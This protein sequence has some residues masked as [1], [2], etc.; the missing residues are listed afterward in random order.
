M[1][2]RYSDILKNQPIYNFGV[3]GHVAH[4]KSTLVRSIT[5]TKTQK[6]SSEKE[7]NIT[8][9]IGYANSKIYIDESGKF[10]TC[11]SNQDFDDDDSLKIVSHISFVDCPGHEAYMS[12]MI[13]GSAVMN[14][15]VL[16]IASN[17]QIPQPQTYEHFQAVKDLDIDNLLILQNKCDLIESS[18][19]ENILNKIN[20]F[21]GDT[22]LS[23]S[24]II[25]SSIQNDINRQEIVY[26]LVKSS[27]LDNFKKLSDK[28]NE[29]LLMTIIRSFDVNKQNCSYHNLKG[30][31][32]GG[33]LITGFLNVNDIVEIRPGFITNGKFRPIY[34][35]VI[36]LQ[37]DNR[38]LEYAVPGGLIGVGLD[39]DPS[40]SKDNGMLGQTLGKVGSLPDV[41]KEIAVEFSF[42]ERLNKLNDIKFK[43][44]ES[45]LIN[46]NSMNIEAKI[47]KCSKK[48]QYLLLNL[49]KPVCINIDQRVAIFKMISGRW[50]LVS[51][52]IFKEGKPLERDD[53][54]EMDDKNSDRKIEIENDIEDIIFKE[55]ESYENLLNN[56]EFKKDQGKK[57]YIPPPVVRKINK[58]S[59]FTNYNEILE[60]LNRNS[61]LIKYD[62][63]LFEFFKQETSTSCEF[64]KNGLSIRGVFRANNIQNIIV[65]FLSK[66]KKCMTCNSF[67]SYLK[68]NSRL[69]I[70]SCIDCKSEF[71]IN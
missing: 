20:S 68:K 31:V 8:I 40:F 38:K 13:S 64:N 49:N 55:A 5:G 42:M 28:I 45:I 6:H 36:S 43:T 58:D 60:F 23:N 46:I 4:G 19:N 52:G 51:N 37:S 53:T 9:N 54:N 16:V 35:K 39:I 10:I 67:N 2:V 47:T 25:P 61:E 57:T 63:L 29:P 69:L 66:Y 32:V 50:I 12:N 18:E 11:P 41:C 70:K 44:D 14:S 3:I 15:C 17:E 65:N 24:P 7:R 27:T 59:V 22:L 21:I 30:G 56:V 48:K 1:I 26:N 71:N 33:S 34:A 62:D